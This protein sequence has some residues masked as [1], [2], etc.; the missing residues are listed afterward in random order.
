MLSNTVLGFEATYGYRPEDITVLKDDPAFAI[1]LQRTR[2]N[3]V[4][5]L[6][7]LLPFL[8]FPSPMYVRPT[9]DF[10][11]SLSAQIEGPR[12]ECGSR[13]SFHVPL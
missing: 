12:C 7:F 10:G 11:R 3:I 8:P 9:L 4:S 13:G 5:T 6:F 1:H 2:E